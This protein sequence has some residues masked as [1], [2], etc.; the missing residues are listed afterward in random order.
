MG[1]FPA[2]PRCNSNGRFTS[3][4][5]HQLEHD[6]IASENASLPTGR[7]GEQ[8]LTFPLTMN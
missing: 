7:S 3:V 2:L 1:H 8:S 6:E 4:N 5:R